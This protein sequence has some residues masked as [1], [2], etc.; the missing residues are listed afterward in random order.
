MFRCRNVRRTDGPCIAGTVTIMDLKSFARR[1]LNTGVRRGVGFVSRKLAEPTTRAAISDFITGG[2]S[3]PAQTLEERPGSPASPG[4]DTHHRGRGDGQ[5]PGHHPTPGSASAPSTHATPQQSP[6]PRPAGVRGTGR[7]RKRYAAPTYSPARHAPRATP[8]QRFPKRPDGGYPGDHT[9]PIRPTYAPDL[10]GDADPGEVIWG[11]V[12]YEEDH[13]KGKDRPVLII[14]HDGHWLLGLMLTSKDNVP[15][16]P[17]EV[18]VDEYGSRYINIGSGDWDPQ[19]R[20]SEI[21]LDR[22]IRIDDR[23]VRREGAVMPM[24]LFSQIVS[25]VQAS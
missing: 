14:G 6:T 18:R 11:W 25:Q 7:A 3:N 10:D 19:G 22:V 5:A 8:K 12:P 16:G 13:T 2:S 4:T 20:P 15:G 21:R 1:T 24:Q 17:G 9:G 23:A